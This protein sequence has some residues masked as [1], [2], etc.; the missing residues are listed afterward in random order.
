MRDQRHQHGG[1]DYGRK[2]LAL[3]KQLFPYEAHHA[4]I[5]CDQRQGVRKIP[6][7]PQKQG[8]NIPAGFHKHGGIRKQYHK[9]QQGK[10]RKNGA[11]ALPGHDGVRPFL[12]GFFRLFIRF[13]FRLVLFGCRLLFDLF[14]R[15][16]FGS[17][18]IS[19][20][21]FFQNPHLLN[22]VVNLYLS[23]YNIF[24]WIYQ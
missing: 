22:L 13:F 19:F 20:V 11:D 24:F 16:F 7:R 3:F 2:Q 6:K 10:Q 8:M 9:R 12:L 17:R 5:N 4:I 18:K 21:L 1:N 15:I 23:Y 14:A